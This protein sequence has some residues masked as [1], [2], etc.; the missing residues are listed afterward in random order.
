MMGGTCPWPS[1]AEP[2]WNS[3]LGLGLH[4]LLHRV[5]RKR[6]RRKQKHQKEKYRQKCFLLTSKS[7]LMKFYATLWP[8]QQKIQ[9]IQ[10]KSRKAR[11]PNK[12]E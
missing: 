7:P 10:P 12:T 6:N 3:W 8:A 4:V 2:W 1:E 11:G 5:E 9:P